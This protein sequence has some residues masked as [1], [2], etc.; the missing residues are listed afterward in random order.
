MSAITQK[1]SDIDSPIAEAAISAKQGYGV[2]A[3]TAAHTV[4]VAG[5]GDVVRGVI[6][7]NGD[8][9]IGEPVQVAHRPGDLVMAIAGGSFN[10][11]DKVN[12]DSAGKF[13]KVTAAGAAFY[14]Y[15]ETTGVSA[16]MFALRIMPGVIN[17]TEFAQDTTN[18]SGEI[19]VA[20]MT[21]AAVVIVTIA[22]DPGSNLALSDVVAG[23][24]KFTVSTRNTNTDA[25]A[26]LNAKKVNYLVLS[27]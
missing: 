6:I 13:I 20:G 8:I 2:K 7:D 17:V 4:D 15:A 23:T 18:S 16:K 5:S 24:G 14:G 26:A 9:A 10:P 22:E 12:T 21:S 27:L 25:R 1:I 19:T 3:G 11:G